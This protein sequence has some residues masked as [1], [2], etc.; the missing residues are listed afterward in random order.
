M[1]ACVPRR[2]CYTC[3]EFAACYL[4]GGGWN[5]G[6]C[7]TA[8]VVTG[9]LADALETL[10]EISCKG[11]GNAEHLARALRRGATNT[12]WGDVL[13]DIADRIKTRMTD[14]GHQR[15]GGK[16]RTEDGRSGKIRS[17]LL[18]KAQ[19]VD[20]MCDF[21]KL[22][23]A[24]KNGRECGR[25]L[26]RACQERHDA[27]ARRCK[28]RGYKPYERRTFKSP[29]AQRWAV[30][31]LRH[32]CSGYDDYKQLQAEAC[33]LLGPNCTQDYADAVCECIHQIIKNRVQDRIVEAFP[34]L[35]EAAEE[36]KV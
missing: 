31:Y 22:A 8:R 16:A 21:P 4:A 10:A 26:D 6:A 25:R 5:C 32:A 12:F 27:Y 28:A 33:K 7:A 13:Q 29:D 24:Y 35:A 11:P 36:Q 17:A 34:E 1:V 23:T 14:Q 30:N 18:R 15:T 20:I 9:R 2:R 3:G 19:T